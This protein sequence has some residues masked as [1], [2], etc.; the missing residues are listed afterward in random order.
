M[1]R[2]GEHSTGLD[3]F[4]IRIG[5]PLKPVSSEASRA[6]PSDWLTGKVL[7]VGDI[8]KHPITKK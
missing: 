2:Y 5:K 4:K 7:T 1:S 3:K 6:Q 8:N